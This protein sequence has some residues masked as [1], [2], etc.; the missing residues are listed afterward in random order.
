MNSKADSKLDFNCRKRGSVPE[1]TQPTSGGCGECDSERPSRAPVC[2]RRN[3]DQETWFWA[4]PFGGRLYSCTAEDKPMRFGTFRI[5]AEWNQ[6]LCSNTSAV[7][8]PQELESR[9]ETRFQLQKR[10]SV[11]AGTLW[12]TRSA[13]VRCGRGVSAL[14]TQ[15]PLCILK[16]GYFVGWQ[17]ISPFR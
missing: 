15:F 3:T 6:M 4:R 12:K 1:G 7:F 10:R 14:Q 5:H 17:P 16:T 9:F 8:L 11:P 13:P 2:S